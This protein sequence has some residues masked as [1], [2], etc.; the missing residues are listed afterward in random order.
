MT[1]LK[2]KDIFKALENA[3][4]E[5]KSRSVSL[6]E[7]IANIYK[8][9]FIEIYI[10]ETYEDIKRNDSST[11]ICSVICGRV[12]TAYAECLFVECAYLSQVSKKIEFGNIVCVNERTI[13][14]LTEVDGEGGLLDTFLSPKDVETVKKSYMK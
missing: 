9:K 5:E 6:A 10:G 13:R 1:L 14:I 4:E 3:R 7:V 12:I 11:K 8:D 2:T